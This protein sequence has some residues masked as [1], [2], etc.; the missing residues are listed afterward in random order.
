MR[1]MYIMRP[2]ITKRVVGLITSMDSYSPD[3][4][5]SI[6]S[7]DSEDDLSNS[8][9]SGELSDDN[10]NPAEQTYVPLV[11]SGR[12]QLHRDKGIN[13][14]KESFIQYSKEVLMKKGIHHYKESVTQHLNSTIDEIIQWI[15]KKNNALIMF[16]AILAI[17]CSILVSSVNESSPK[18]KQYYV[19]EEISN[20]YPMHDKRDL[21][22]LIRAINNVNEGRYE[23]DKVAVITILYSHRETAECLAKTTAN[24]AVKVINRNE[25]FVRLNGSLSDNFYLGN[26]DFKKDIK[27]K[28][29]LVV[30][31]FQN[32]PAD[33][34]RYFHGICDKHT[35]YIE[36]KAVYI[37]LLEMS[38]NQETISKKLEKVQSRIEE[39]WSNLKS[40]ILNPLGIRLMDN[41][42]VVQQEPK[43]L[44]C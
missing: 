43:L 28:G 37:I 7:N 42:M 6:R 1:T 44:W 39:L 14:Y 24:Y 19:I 2:G 23:T 38:K 31:D 17:V 35:P 3:S 10:Q 27:N 25:D 40:E 34:V 41:V 11:I 22:N 30:Y 33:K 20:Q 12:R 21:I 8:S 13:Y 32:F 36:D 4:P 16:I 15:T 5:A 9:N 29:V 18:S 26:E